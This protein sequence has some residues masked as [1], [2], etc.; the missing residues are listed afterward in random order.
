MPHHFSISSLAGGSPD[1]VLSMTAAL[2]TAA[3]PLQKR[4][5]K[6]KQLEHSAL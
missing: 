3:F 5:L 2:A 6:R 4:L 1:E